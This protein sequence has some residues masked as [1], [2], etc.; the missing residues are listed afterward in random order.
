MTKQ[1]RQAGRSATSARGRNS[2]QGA[3]RKGPQ[4]KPQRRPSA[5]LNRLIIVTGAGVVLVAALQAYITLQSI[6]VQHITV[7]GE[8]EHTRTDLV[9]DMV[10]PALVGGFL[11]ADLQR[12]QAQLEELPW[13]YQATVQRR[14]P[15]ALEIHVIE[16]LPIAR[17]GESDFLNHE[18]E[19]FRSSSSKEWQTLP[20]LRGPEGS[21]K[22]LVAG[23]QRIVEILRPL[24]LAVVQLA[25]DER[26]QVA[27]VLEGGM[28]LLLGSEDFLERMHRFVAIYRS[29]LG[30]RATEVV[31]V[32][33]RYETGIAVAFNEESSQVAGL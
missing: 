11:R 5:W 22:A 10:Q 2:A 3:T 20:Q 13:I 24:H 29:E 1:E 19:V 16:Q 26:G 14:W 4:V 6:P 9:Q 25:V 31:R 23:Y 8:L 27:V 15:N 7:T 30:T 33:L 28:Q 18:G 12:I 32:D 21:A 17:W